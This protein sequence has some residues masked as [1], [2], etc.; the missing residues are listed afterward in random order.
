MIDMAT[1]LSIEPPAPW[2]ARAAI[3]QPIPGARP[4]SSEPAPKAAKP[5]W[6]KRRRPT[7]SAVDPAST[8]KLASTRVY[9]STVHCKPATEA[10]RSRRMA[11][12]ATLTIEMSITTTAMLAQQIAST[13]DRRRWLGSGMRVPSA[14][15]ARDRRR[16]LW[17]TAY[18]ARI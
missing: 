13:R 8:R 9:A 10:C 3:S 18:D 4:H 15:A 16:G 1:G 6:N 11:G 7:R 14:G 12:S 5:A 17:V 2:S